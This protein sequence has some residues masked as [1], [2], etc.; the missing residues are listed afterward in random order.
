MIPINIKDVENELARR[1]LKYFISCLNSS[2]EFTQFHESYIKVLDLFAK[3]K[4]H[5]V[6]YLKNMDIFD[7]L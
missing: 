4:M 5:L 6:H 1:D 3:K 2:Y 7:K